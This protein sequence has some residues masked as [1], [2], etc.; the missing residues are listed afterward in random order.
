MSYRLKVLKS[1]PIVYYATRIY[2]RTIKPYNDV[3][4]NNVL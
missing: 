2:N 4:N 1:H 3:L